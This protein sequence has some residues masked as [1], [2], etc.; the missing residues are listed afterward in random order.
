MSCEVAV[1]EKPTKK[2]AEDG[3]SERLVLA[4]VALCAPSLDV[5]KV[6]AM[7]KVT[8]DVAPERLE[9]Y[10]RPFAR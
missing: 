9:V 3:K 4:P 8:E 6:L 2:E 5:A 1:V 7:R 10:A